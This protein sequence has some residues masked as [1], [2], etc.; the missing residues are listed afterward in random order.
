MSPLGR[1]PQADVMSAYSNLIIRDDIAFSMVRINPSSEH[2]LMPEHYSEVEI[3]A[4][5]EVLFFSCLA[6]SLPPDNGMIWTYPLS[7]HKDLHIESLPGSS[8]T[9]TS[10]EDRLVEGARALSRAIPAEDYHTRTIVPP[11]LSG[12]PSYIRHQEPF[13]EYALTAMLQQ[14]RLDEW[15][16]IRGLGALLRADMLWQHRE[17]SESSIMALHVAME[18]SF[19]IVREKLRALGNPNPSAHDAGAYLDSVFNTG[20][21][22]GPYFHD[23]YEDRIKS[24]H[25]SSRFGV[26]PFSPLAA[27]DYYD[28]RHDLHE[29]FLYL[30]TGETWPTI[31]G[32]GNK[33]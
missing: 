22:T 21:A 4:L 17:F 31:K 7:L 2:R 3:Y 6:L 28:L 18:A 11:P 30:L 23:Y 25:P 27:D 5:E 14:T 10:D 16:A 26:F 12:G 20:L 19:Q 24:S 29:V 1:Y 32:D 8:L 33:I 15:V 13:S 9:N